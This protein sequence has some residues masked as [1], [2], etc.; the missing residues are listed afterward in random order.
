L[1]TALR[2]IHTFGNFNRHITWRALNVFALSLICLVFLMNSSMGSE[3]PIASMPDSN[4]NF[5]NPIEV[6]NENTIDIHESD[7]VIFRRHVLSLKRHNVPV[8]WVQI[9]NVSF[10]IALASPP[11]LLTVWRFFLFLL[12]PF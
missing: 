7:D 2:Y 9:P 1:K 11:F 5:T 10:D 3:V 6:I 8:A 12:Y 4:I